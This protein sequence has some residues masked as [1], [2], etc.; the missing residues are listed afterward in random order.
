[1]LHHSGI[2]Q[3]LKILILPQQSLFYVAE[4]CTVLHWSRLSDHIGRK[5]VALIGLMSLSLSMYGFGLSR[6]FWGLVFRCKQR[7]LALGNT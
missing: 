1:M 3:H 2:V 7:L 4:A 5:P 6:T